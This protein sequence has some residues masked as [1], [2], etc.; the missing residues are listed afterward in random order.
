MQYAF[1]MLLAVS[2]LWAKPYRGGELRS[3]ETFRYG[4]F[5]VR[6]RSV[7]GSGTVSSFFTY[8]E[9]VVNGQLDLNEID[10]E[11]LGRYT[12]RVQ[13]NTITGNHDY[14]IQFQP[15]E[16]D[17]ATE[18]HTY[19]IEWTPDYVSW[20]VDSLVCYTQE[21]GHVDSLDRAQRL[22][23]NIWI[24][25]FPDWVGPFDPQDLPRY[26]C[27]DWVKVYDF[28]PGAGRYGTD[29]NFSLRWVDEF[30]SWDTDRWEKGN[31]T[32]RKNRAKFTPENVVFQEG[33]LILCLTTRTAT[34][35]DAKNASAACCS[36]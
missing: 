3:I 35:C 11:W 2:A 5:E 33:C 12:D 23:M 29:Q 27:Y 8:N 18:F 31:H 20:S 4:R 16:F 10:I 9:R 21:G 32:W 6:C 28:T 13:Y 24:P 36:P 22:I 34:G 14:H 25:D 7:G 26:A 15:L 17:P 1:L 30:E 19:A